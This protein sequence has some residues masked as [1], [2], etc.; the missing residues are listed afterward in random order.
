MKK[1]DRQL[2]ED[3]HQKIDIIFWAMAAIAS[4]TIGAIIAL[5]LYHDKI[6]SGY[7]Q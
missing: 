4:L 6:F 3:I 7:V 2:L 1:T 5:V